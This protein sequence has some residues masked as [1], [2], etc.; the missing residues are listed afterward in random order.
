MNVLND[1]APEAL[2]EEIRNALSGLVASLPSGTYHLELI[3]DPEY[4]ERGAVVRLSPANER[5]A[6]VRISVA[7][8]DRDAVIDFGRNSRIELFDRSRQP[9]MGA[10]SLVEECRM[11]ASAVVGGEVREQVVWKGESIIESKAVLGMP[12][13]PITTSSH[14]LGSPLL[15]RKRTETY[16]Y[17]PYVDERA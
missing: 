11:I 5:S 13:Q 16:E 7:H 14:V 12:T 1:E 4:P 8:G 6:S 10:E 15:G 2:A 3:A 17:A 9:D